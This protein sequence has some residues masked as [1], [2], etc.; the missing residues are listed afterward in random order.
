MLRTSITGSLITSSNCTRI[1]GSACSINSNM[2]SSRPS[3]CSLTSNPLASKSSSPELSSRSSRWPQTILIF[4]AVVKKMAQHRSYFLEFGW[5][6]GRPHSDEQNILKR[7]ASEARRTSL[8]STCALTSGTAREHTYFRLMTSSRVWAETPLDC[9]SLIYGM[10]VSSI[11]LI[12]FF[13][14]TDPFTKAILTQFF[15]E[16]V[17]RLPHFICPDR[18]VMAQEDGAVLHWERHPK[19]I[20]ATDELHWLRRTPLS[21]FKTQLK[22]YYI[23]R[24]DSESERNA[25]KS[26]LI[27][28]HPHLECEKTG[29]KSYK[30]KTQVG[31]W[32]PNNLVV[33]FRLPIAPHFARRNSPS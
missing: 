17:V 32:I 3:A 7:L 24:S 31:R 16:S 9:K 29:L 33:C 4:L 19:G 15:S 25:C 30:S 14:H 22:I 23:H 5:H 2:R 27:V 21:V 26:L 13:Q 12:I 20:V 28:F 6:R 8:T 1:R 11:W 18:W 10:K